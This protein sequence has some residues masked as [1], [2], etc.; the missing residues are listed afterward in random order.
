MSAEFLIPLLAADAA[1]PLTLTEIVNCPTSWALLLGVIGLWMMMGG[2]VLSVLWD[3]LIAPFSAK[4]DPA[5]AAVAPPRYRKTIGGLLLII[6]LGL[7]GADLP[8]LS[9]PM[10]QSVFWLMAAVTLVS[11]I[12]CITAQSPVYSALWFAM[13]LLG[14]AGLFFLEGAQFLA[15]ATIV[16]YAGAIV[17][18]FLFVLMLAQPEGHASYDRISWGWFP[19]A[20]SV[21]VAGAIVAMLTLTLGG[22]KNQAASAGRELSAREAMA[23]AAAKKSAAETKRLEKET[24]EVVKPV[25]APTAPANDILHPQ[26]MARL[27]GYLF[28]RHLISIEV[29]GTLLLAAL[30]GAVAIAIQGKQRDRVDE[31]LSAA[32]PRTGAGS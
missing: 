3:I 31:A 18:T 4:T 29:A 16:V 11:G 12:G 14:T 1:K 17:V 30:V 9:N 2:S 28:T 6:S 7:F 20:A 24:T 8:W 19:R 26:H 32:I 5:P 27:G 13:S 15:V 21:V 25:P 23:Q 22:L 10:A